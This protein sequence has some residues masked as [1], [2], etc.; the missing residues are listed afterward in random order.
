MS[1]IVAVGLA[2]PLTAEPLLVAE[3]LR[4]DKTRAKGNKLPPGQPFRVRISPS[5]PFAFRSFC[6]V[7]GAVVRVDAD[8]DSNSEPTIC[9]PAVWVYLGAMLITR[10]VIAD[11]SVRSANRRDWE[12][13]RYH[14]F[15]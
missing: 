3:M 4:G 7:P 6:A 2:R 1:F 5:E 8:S 11:R 10:P 9:P 12:R 15:R 13:I 14:G